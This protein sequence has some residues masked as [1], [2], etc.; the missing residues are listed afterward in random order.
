MLGAISVDKKIA[1]EVTCSGVVNF[2]MQQ[3]YVPI[4]KRLIVK[5]LEQDI[6]HGIEISITVE[7]EFAYVWTTKIESIPPQQSVEVSTIDIKL[8]PN[9]LYSLTE[10]MVG[11]I[12]IN[13]NQVEE[14]LESITQGIDILAYDEWSGTQIMPEIV[15]AFITPN[16]PKIAEIIGRARQLLENWSG[17]PSFSGYQTNNPN[18]V[19]MQ[20]AAIYGALQK[21]NIAYCMPPASYEL[22]GQRVRLCDAI[23]EQ[24]LGTCLDLSLLYAG[25]LEFVGL[26]P[27]VIFLK[28]HAFIG[29]WLEEKCFAECVQDDVSLLTK[30]I[31]EGINEICLVE[32]TCFVAGKNIQFDNAIKSGESNLNDSGQFE[33]LVDVK[34]TRGSGIRPIP[35]RKIM[36]DGKTICNDLEFSNTKDSTG[37]TNAP[38]EI[39]VFERINQVEH[40]DVTRQQIWERKLLDLSLRNTLVNF[41]VTKNAIQL[42]ANQLSELEDALSSGQEFQILARPKDFENTLRDSKIYAAENQ[43]SMIEDLVKTEFANNRIRTFVEESEVSYRITSLF[44]QA[45]VSLEE[46]GTNTLYLALGFLRWY[47]SDVS[48][49]AR[50]APLVL[51]PID[52]IRKSAQK[53]YVIRVRDEETQ[54]NITLLEMLR[55]D[56]GI[57]IGGL[58][59]LPSDESGVDLRRVFNTMR[60]A[61]MEKSRWDVEELAFIGLFS[62][63]QFIM[64]NDIRNRADDL[65]K[66]K[67]VA[68][69]LS[70]K[71]E[72]QPNSDFPSLDSLDTSFTPTDLAVP[73]S[74]DSS[75]LSAICAAGKGNSFVLHGPPGTGKSQTITNIIANALFQGKSVLF[76]AEKMAALSVVQKRLDSIG[77]APFCLELHSNKA[78]K[79]DV[80]EQL[81]QALSIGKIK[82]PEQYEEQ[83]QRLYKL[84]QELNEVVLQI[85]KKRSFGFSLYDAITKYEQYKSASD[86][87]RF[88]QQQI[89]QLNP[90]T[91]TQWKDTVN[92]LKLA[93]LE[94][95][96]IS[97]NPLCEFTNKNYSQSKKSEIG[98]N[99]NQYHEAVSAFSAEIATLCQI[100]SFPKIGFTYIQVK[101]IVELVKLLMNI[102]VMPVALIENQEISSLH[103]QVKRVCDCG[104]RRDEIEKQLLLVFSK[105]IL[106]YDDVAAA[107]QWKM[108]AASWFLPKLL[109]QSKVIK[110]LKI[111]ANNPSE[112]DKTKTEIYINLVAEYKAN[113]KVVE[114][115]SRDL[116]ALFSVIWNDALPDWNRIETC[117]GQAV[118]CDELLSAIA[119]DAEQKQVFRKALVNHVFVNLTGFQQG[120]Q[121]TFTEIATGYERVTQFESIL[122]EQ[123]GIDF[124]KQKSENNWLIRMQTLTQNW[125]EHLDGLRSWCSYLNIKEQA[126]Q[127]GLSNV[128]EALEAGTVSEEDLPSAFYRG[129][130][131]ACAISIVD[132]E[133]CLSSFNGTIFED[134]IEKYKQTCGE[135][136]NLTKNELVAR[137]SAKIPATSASFANSSEIGILQKAIRSGGR[138]LSI[139]K[140]FDSIPNLLRRLCPCML[141]S[142]ISVAQYIDPNYPPFDLIVFDEASQL[143]TCEAV[144]A[145]AR[146]NDVIVVGDPKQLPPTSFFSVNR[147]DEDNFEKEDLESILDDCLALSM[148]QEHLLWHYRSRH[149][150]LIAFSNMQYYDNKLFTFPSPNDMISQVKYIAVDGFYD[151]GKTK[152]NDAEAK[153]I[154]A[155][156]V[157][158]LND[159]ILSKQSIGVVTFSS[160]Q[161]N[162]IDDLLMEAFAKNPQLEDINNAMYEPVFIKN[163]ENVQGDERDVILFSIGYGPDTNGKVALNFG[164]LNRDG[165]WRRLNVAVSRAR[166]EMIVFSTLRPEQIDLS[167][168]RS[169]GIAGLKAFLEFAQKGKSML[170]LKQTSVLQNEDTAEKLIAEQIKT[171]GYEVHTNIGCSEYKIDI[172]VVHPN[173]KG[174]YILGIMCDGM[175]YYSANTARDRNILQGG[176]LKS[177]GWNIYHLWILDWWENQEKVLDKIKAAIKIALESRGK[178]FEPQ[179]VV[180]SPNTICS[181]EKVEEANVDDAQK[182]YKKYE[183]CS[184]ISEKLGAE[185]FCLPQ[186]NRLI[187]IQINEVLAKE[188][189]I[190]RNALCKRILSA[191]GIARMGARLER[192][193]DEL[194]TMLGSQQTTSNGTVFYWNEGQQSSTYELFRV[195]S[196]DVT[197]RNMEDISAEEISNAVK[198]LLA[199]QVSLSTEDL[200]K[201]VYKLFGFSRSSSSIEEIIGAGISTAIDRG[202]VLRDATDRVIIQE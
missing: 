43:T 71:M 55:Q 117:Y 132:K 30:R 128:V 65:K 102:N 82:S 99:L 79:K 140:L 177:L 27:L 103:D 173:K 89:E 138:M 93:G 58:D 98:E 159:P 152:Q 3:N 145:I 146:G 100:V 156:I 69:L 6:L 37:V 121:H 187:L 106:T 42:M 4:I 95:G 14:V 197:R 153:A 91:Y 72:W 127:I 15:S 41:R 200:F 61:V 147:I 68:S 154:I 104:K 5:N 44:R 124:N 66:N 12:F 172:G 73:I 190:S 112:Y 119:T 97:L 53:G 76:I 105:E 45:K 189:P 179:T 84:R 110:S 160:V 114:E 13:V 75:Q 113:V 17:S 157:R 176:V 8:S 23:L 131:L 34:R 185:E 171:L 123:T 40:I 56:F 94:F 143:P 1:I 49:K 130:S 193:F 18:T 195:P 78:K 118:L 148:P 129:V 174:E 142:P 196:D 47:E 165:G 109:G 24:R 16:H 96:K 39:E 194:F 202:Y 20:M 32:C 134:E 192:R 186:N 115:N 201:E 92:Q 33:L 120:N 38:K 164:P 10:K 21:E 26:N 35:L 162:L 87:I 86:C 141:M 122:S 80:L 77:L 166:K 70:G 150:S 198:S 107:Q 116:S 62:F 83:A 81:E 59:P 74:A 2:A 161:Q 155:E 52:I 108:A 181:Y 50:Y 188:A 64:W 101:V 182:K 137:L 168:T 184:I 36:T 135:F 63:S 180:P 199:D 169:D 54:M 158:R 163:L 90:Q 175:N 149:E 183:C 125:I 133:S 167:K 170:S 139:R 28:G 48:E 144:G 29:C 7:P 46:N 126:Q 111:L 60:Q 67:I 51:L 136:E 11:T 57:M 151:R 9:Y 31:V 25:C 191:W 85:H 88:S 19:K 178:E 22:V